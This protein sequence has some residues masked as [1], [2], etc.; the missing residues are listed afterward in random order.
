MTPH[1][2]EFADRGLT[3]ILSSL[4]AQIRK[5]RL[6]S[7][8]NDIA[9]MVVVNPA[10]PDQGKVWAVTRE[11]LYQD[12]L[13][14]YPEA[15]RARCRLALQPTD[16]YEVPFVVFYGE[17]EVFSGLYQLDRKQTTGVLS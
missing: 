8:T 12:V 4:N 2:R 6:V 15:I 3:W 16:P 10:T 7:S 13:A 14:T 9:M 17:A 11:A 5:G 1:T